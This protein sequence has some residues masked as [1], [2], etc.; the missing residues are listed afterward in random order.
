M[1]P[2]TTLKIWQSPNSHPVQ[3]D[4]KVCII[5]PS[6][7]LIPNTKNHEWIPYHNWKQ[8]E[9]WAQKATINFT[10]KICKQYAL[11]NMKWMNEVIEFPLKVF[12]KGTN[13]L[14]FKFSHTAKL[15]GTCHELG[16]LLGPWDSEN[17]MTQ[18]IPLKGSKSTEE[19]KDTEEVLKDINM[20]Y[21]ID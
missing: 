18:S 2:T 6:N 16:T 11:L 3:F 4:S 12:K 5:H 21:D 20:D 1:Y 13:D 9:R 7:A 19:G 15:L 14:Q 8:T 10:N 17:N